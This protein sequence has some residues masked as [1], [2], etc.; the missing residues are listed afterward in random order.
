MRGHIVG[1][2]RKGQLIR[3]SDRV[4]MPD[5]QDGDDWTQGNFEATVDN[6][7]EV[8]ENE[9]RKKYIVVRDAS[10][11]YFY[12][13]P[14][15]VY[16]DTPYPVY[17][18]EDIEDLPEGLYLALFHGYASES[19]RNQKEDWGHNGPV[20]GP[21]DDYCQ[22]TYATH[23][24]FDFKDEKDAK[25]YGLPSTVITELPINKDGCVEYEG[26]QY[27]DWTVMYHKGGM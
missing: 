25:K 1:K 15:R 9:R 13:E 3:I 11:D 14:Q 8:S 20:I 5:P 24:K 18:K 2:D 22:T 16:I 23:I 6:S 12:V 19:E 27:G 4:I 21:L 17:C 10:N 26:I 7:K